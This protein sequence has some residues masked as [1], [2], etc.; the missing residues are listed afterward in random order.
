MP[1]TFLPYLTFLGVVVGGGGGGV[2]RV[3]EAGT[4][5]LFLLIVRKNIFHYKL[6]HLDTTD[7]LD[8]GY[9]FMLWAK[10]SEQ[11]ERAICREGGGGNW[12]NLVVDLLKWR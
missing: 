1:C 6:T 2:G 12:Y 7:A 4:H 9:L 8:T 5:I 11:P 3:G 10:L